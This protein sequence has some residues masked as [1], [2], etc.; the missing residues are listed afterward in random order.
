MLIIFSETNYRYFNHNGD[1][2]INDILKATVVV[3]TFTTVT[4]S[5]NNECS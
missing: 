5:V 1:K 4:Y 2:L 3:E